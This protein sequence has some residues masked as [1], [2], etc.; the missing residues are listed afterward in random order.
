MT[1]E[2]TDHDEVKGVFS[3][4]YKAQSYKAE[5]GDWRLFVAK[6]EVDNP[7]Y[8]DYSD[9]QAEV[10]RSHSE[11]LEPNFDLIERLGLRKA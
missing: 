9:W 8:V 10:K 11:R 6:L 3:S 4:A 5:L 1:S 2:G 7:D